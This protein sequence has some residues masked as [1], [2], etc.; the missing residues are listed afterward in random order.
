MVTGSKNYIEVYASRFESAQ[1]DP[2]TPI[3]TIANGSRTNVIEGMVGHSFIAVD[4]HANPGVSV[5][6]GK[7][8]TPKDAT[9]NLLLNPDLLLNYD[10]EMSLTA[11]EQNFRGLAGWFNLGNCMAVLHVDA[12][13]A[14]YPKHALLEV[15]IPVG[16]TCEIAPAGI[17]L[18]PSAATRYVTFGAHV[19]SAVAG[20]V[21]VTLR[22]PQGSIQSSSANT[23]GWS[24]VGMRVDQQDQLIQPKLR[25]SNPTSGPV[26]LNI[27]A[28]F[29]SFGNG[30]PTTGAVRPST[31]HAT[32]TYNTSTSAHDYYHVLTPK[33][34][35]VFRIVG[36][37]HIHRLN[38]PTAERFAHGTIITLIVTTPIGIQNSSYI[39]LQR[40]WVPVASS[41]SHRTISLMSNGDGSWVEVWRG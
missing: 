39:N 25:L 4:Q 9:E 26:Y 41:E 7:S 38:Q 34:A 3:I 12:R 30:V 36:S 11:T 14:L 35:S 1:Q 18:T 16:T 23:E 29:L 5:V 22:S 10:P 20:A 13:G 33:S 19:Q 37:K 32:S 28:P 17:P 6:T 31:I 2:G 8:V 40:S 15:T 21:I 27:T 24:F